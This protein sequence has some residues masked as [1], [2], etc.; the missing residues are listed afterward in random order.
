MTPAMRRALL[1]ALAGLALPASANAQTITTDSTT[2]AI[3]QCTGAASTDPPLSADLSLGLTWTVA[4]VSNSTVAQGDIYRLYAAGTQPAAGQTSNGTTGTSCTLDVNGAG[5]NSNQFGSDMTVTSTV[6]SGTQTFS[7]AEVASKAGY[8]C[9]TASSAPVYLC[10]QWLSSASAVKGYATATVTLDRTAPPAPT[11]VSTTPGDSVLHVGCSA[12]SGS[13]STSNFIAKATSVANP[14]E[15]HYSNKA[16]S[17]SDV[18][19][20]NLTN[21]QQYSVVVWG[22]SASNNPSAASEPATGAPVQTD[23]FWNR[24]RNA[25]GR[26][27]GGCSTAAGAASLLSALGLLALRRRKP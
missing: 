17:C 6:V 7:M 24:Y 5:I 16:S 25:G 3:A 27:S 21:G 22:V 13:P 10:V 19:L 12:G 18:V 26:D 14:A 1:V 23:D 9:T 11:S 20:E 15:I 4:A 8:D 2:I